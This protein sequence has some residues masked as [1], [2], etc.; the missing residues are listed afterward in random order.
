MSQQQFDTAEFVTQFEDLFKK[1]SV[2][3]RVYRT[4]RHSNRK[5]TTQV[6]VS[7][8][9]KGKL[10]LELTCNCY[11][12]ATNDIVS[13]VDEVKIRFGHLQGDRVSLGHSTLSY[14]VPQDDLYRQR[15]FGVIVRYFDV[16]VDDVKRSA[17]MNE[18][19]AHPWQRSAITE[20]Q[21]YAFDKPEQESEEE[22]SRGYRRT[23][24]LEHL[25]FRK[26]TLNEVR[27]YGLVRH[28]DDETLELT[29]GEPVMTDNDYWFLVSL[30]VSSYAYQYAVYNGKDLY[31]VEV[32]TKVGSD[33]QVFTF[34]KLADDK[35]RLCPSDKTFID[36]CVNGYLEFKES[37]KEETQV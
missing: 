29:R 26:N 12:N 36:E 20:C 33:N 23:S 6:T 9:K 24:L 1:Q 21:T 3:N 16:C 27:V 10:V 14:S 7:R 11:E 19:Y 4:L 25:T 22:T 15:F 28:V 31:A 8:H 30:H 17:F 18:L 35:R 37:K 2:Y 34:A 32:K 13:R 5:T